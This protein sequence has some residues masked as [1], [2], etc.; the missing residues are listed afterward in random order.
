MKVFAES[1]VTN[2]EKK[3][4]RA[5]K[6]TTPFIAK[7]A[8]DPILSKERTKIE[9]WLQTLPKDVKPDILG[10]LRSKSSHQH[11]SAYYELV[12]REF[13]KSMGYSVT[14]R[15]KLKE[16]EPDL[17]VTGK[18]LAKPI[19][20]E[21][22]TVF[23]DPEW[24]REERKLD[25]ILEQLDKIEHYFFVMVAVES[26]PI[27]ERVD[28]ESLQQFVTQWL[29]SFDP[30]I[31]HESQETGYQS[32]GL[33]LKV[34]M[35]PRKIPK[36]KPIVGSYRLPARF[37]NSIQVRRVLEKKINKYKSLK[38]LELPFIIAL[39]LASASLDEEA[40]IEELFGKEQTIIK[41]KPGE[42]VI[43]TESGRDF[44]GLLTPKPGLGGKTR[45]TR[46]SAVLEVKS[47]WSPLKEANREAERKHF[48]RV[49]H[50][51]FSSTPL[52]HRVFKDYPQ[53]VP[54]AED[55]KGISLQW[56]GENT[57]VAF[58]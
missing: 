51:P 16:G 17:L 12:L 46:L 20:I 7:L 13:F 10:R 31:I 28:Y 40:I 6:Y 39:S 8:I 47:K 33:K 38:K 52:D 15:P 48:L 53:L 32:D 2:L 18:N 14:I 21:V 3:Y 30:K 44:S 5:S 35:I 24:E 55:D 4:H 26:E 49:M 1:W 27:P 58:S 36:R 23:D 9:E 41:S 45:N 22:A 37:M 25:L 56:I 57:E 11:F 29:D 19:I 34:T 54:V 42:E 43:E 50:N